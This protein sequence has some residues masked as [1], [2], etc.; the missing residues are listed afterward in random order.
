[1]KNNDKE[2]ITV[3]FQN[4]MNYGAILQC[5]ALQ[6]VISKKYPNVK[7][8]NYNNKIIS[9]DYAYFYRGGKTLFQK[10]KNII[11]GVVFFPKNYKRNKNF[12]KFISN[13]IK[14]TRKMNKNEITKIYIK[15]NNIFIAGSDQIWNTEITKGFDDIYFLNFSESIKKISY[16]ASIG[17]SS[18]DSSY[19]DLY[20]NVLKKYSFI[21]VREDSAKSNLQKLLKKEIYSVL[22]PTLLLS[23]YDWNNLVNNL[24]VI[25]EKYIFVYM[26]YGP[27]VEIAKKI[28]EYTGYKIIY[29][30]KKNIFK[31]GKNVYGISPE[32]FVNL[33]KNAEYI[34]T[35]SFH[36]VAF[37]V[38]FNKKFWVTI[39]EKVGSR[40]MDFLKLINLSSRIV[41]NID[42][43]DKKDVK[44]TI[45]YDI[46]N[47]I[48]EREK[49]K[50]LKL[51]YNAIDE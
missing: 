24:D 30:E 36:A 6:N 18:I 31:N 34:V 27:C 9:K 41:N 51:L 44:E 13:N 32:Q 10:I 39:P 1:M 12:N 25:K 40:I 35:T 49:K 2:I 37:S 46:I 21:S 43:L 8:L 5:Y 11:A 28:S 4:A 23:K 14:F 17:N 19:L 42:E 7:T 45:N 20:K 3:T 38:I 33:I 16:A 50:S 48:L 47:N 22:D 15:S 26:A 29:I